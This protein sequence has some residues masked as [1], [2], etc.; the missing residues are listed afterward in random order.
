MQWLVL[1]IGL[2]S[3]AAGVFL[4][5]R[6]GRVQGHE[7]TPSGRPENTG[8]VSPTPPPPRATSEPAGFAGSSSPGVPS[9]AAR[10]GSIREGQHEP[11][12]HAG[13][14]FYRLAPPGPAR[15]ALP[16]SVTVEGSRF[17]AGRYC[18]APLSLA[19]P[20]LFGPLVARALPRALWQAL[21]MGADQ[22]GD[23]MLWPWAAGI[24]ALP[25]RFALL[26]PSL[27]L[28]E[29]LALRQDPRL[30]LA[31]LVI[32]DL[33]LGILPHRSPVRNGERPPIN[34]ASTGA[35]TRHLRGSIR[36]LRQA[37][38]GAPVVVGLGI[39]KHLD[40]EMCLMEQAE[41]DGVLLFGS[42]LATPL[43]LPTAAPSVGYPLAVGLESAR[44]RS[45]DGK[46][47]TGI[48]L[49]A[50]GLS[51][52]ADCLKA[53]A[54]GADALVLDP[55]DSDTLLA[56]LRQAIQSPGTMGQLLAE[57]TRVHLTS[58][59]QETTALLR[60]LGCR[61]PD[62]LSPDLLLPAPTL[63]AS[64]ARPPSSWPPPPSASPPVAPPD[65]CPASSKAPVQ[66]RPRPLLAGPPH[67]LRQL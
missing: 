35:V 63:R 57:R 13:L 51:T 2:I 58:L 10:N 54:L 38:G 31:A 62:E 30:S 40:E 33:R 19:H 17:L 3:L 11:A 56:T 12:P 43:R 1:T 9:A 50:G 65:S 49:A 45:Q 60:L 20:W 39:G 27:R 21:A 23:I 42:P 14:D 32:L 46:A 44:T 55:W 18:T 8:P 64:L 53:L 26:L 52:P 24:N 4:A 25:D 29:A 41:A 34:G 61:S 22:A 67:R 5:A 16:P 47:P 48:L 7:Y 6:S 28:G 66:L 15:P 37:S 59:W 36:Y